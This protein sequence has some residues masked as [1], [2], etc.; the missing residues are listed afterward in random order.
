MTNRTFSPGTATVNIAATA[1]SASVALNP[2]GRTCRVVNS[3]AAPVFIH[4]S[5]DPA[6]VATTTMSMPVL[7]N[8]T[9]TFNKGVLSSVSAVSTGTSTVYFTVG[10]GP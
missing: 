7:P 10:D 2:N 1:T 6:F 5:N 8:T 3:G 9:E 4:F